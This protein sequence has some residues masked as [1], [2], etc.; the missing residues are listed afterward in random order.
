MLNYWLN[1][2]AMID[3]KH[4]LVH[5][6]ALL[7]PTSP[8]AKLDA[9]ILL[10]YTLGRSRTYLYT[11]PEKQ[12]E[13]IHYEAYQQ[14][15]AKRS[16]GNPIAY[17]TNTREFW[18]LSLQIC[19]DTLIPR[20]ETELLVELTL[21]LLQDVSPASIIDLGTGSGAIAIA[22]A[23]ERPDWQIQA[24]D[25]NPIAVD[26][27]QFNAKQLGLPNVKVCHSNW[28][29]SVSKQQFHAIVSNPPY[30]AQNDP[31]LKQGDVRFEPQEALVGG[32]NGLE[33]LIYIIEHSHEHLLPGGLLLVEHG[34]DQKLAVTSCLTQC[35]YQGV[36]CWQDAQGHDRVSGGWRNK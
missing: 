9:E 6:V 34:F 3:I 12:L 13:Q 32:E 17:L 35:G 22:L 2:D 29:S 23:S 33:T 8:S 26:T 19:K 27:A 20:P 11:H 31:H 7:S 28:F 30:I 36:E 21:K 18:S 5:A 15:I 16:E 10:A 4:A 14:L 24:Y 25:I 1:W